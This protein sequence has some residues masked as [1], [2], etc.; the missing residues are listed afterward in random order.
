ML[1]AQI[2][3]NQT[4]IMWRYTYRGIYPIAQMQHMIELCFVNEGSHVKHIMEHIMY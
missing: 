3:E 4:A 2:Y 1:W